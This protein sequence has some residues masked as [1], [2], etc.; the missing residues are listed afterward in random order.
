MFAKRFGGEQLENDDTRVQ[1]FVLDAINYEC[2]LI[3]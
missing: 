2:T 1:L 3:M